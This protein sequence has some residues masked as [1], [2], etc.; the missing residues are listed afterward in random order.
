MQSQGKIKPMRTD[1]VHVDYPEPHRARTR[2]ILRKHPEARELFGPNPYSALILLGLVGLQIGLAWLLRDSAVWMIVIVAWCVGAVIDHTLYI[3]IHEVAHNLIFKKRSHNQIAGL[4]ANLP[5]C[6]PLSAPFSVYHL[7]HHRF[8][9]EY[10]R[11]P[12][13]ARRWE[14]RLIGRS[15]WGK[16]L[17]E[18]LYPVIST[19]RIIHFSIKARMPMFPPWVVANCLIQGV[20]VAIVLVL[21]G[22]KALLYL[23]LNFI[24]SLGP[25]PLGA[26]IIQEHYVVNGTQETY[27]YYGPMNR[28][29]LNVGYHNEHHDLPFI[30]WNRLPKFKKIAPEFYGP[31]YSYRS[32]AR[33]WFRFLTD[34]NITLFS[35]VTRTK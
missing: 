26:R 5:I 17:W 9:G 31:L 29:A 1:F 8:Q 33:L 32:W 11:D 24:F 19:S 21:L 34:P 4:I 3:L 18:C 13:I 30:A 23:A 2:E 35:R 15:I 20:F 28:V 7:M 14:G 10:D 6:F 22:P 12:D 16:L 25:H 27:S